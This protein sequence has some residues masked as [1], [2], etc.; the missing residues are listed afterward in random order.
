MAELVL[1][2]N[3]VSYKGFEQVQISR[4]M[5][6]IC[7]GFVVSAN[8]FF[9]GGTNS[10]QIKIGQGV[11]IE[12]DGQLVLDG[13]IDKMPI[14][15]G[16][17]TDN[18]EIYGRDKT[19]DLVDCCFDFTPNE[20]KNQ[21][22]GNL[23]KNL[24]NPFGIAVEVDNTATTESNI[25]VETFK[26]NEGIPVY[27]LISEL[28]RDQ[29]ILPLCYGDGKLTLTKAGGNYA[30]DSI[31][32]GI[33]ILK[34]K[35]LL[36]NEDRYSSYKVKG[37]GIGTDEKAL[38]DFISCFGEFSDGIITRTRPYVEFAESVTNNGQCKKK[39][40][41]IAR[42]KAGLSRANVYSISNWIQTTGKVWKINKLVR[43]KDRFA[44]ID[45]TM[46][47]FSVD[48]TYYE[49][50]GDITQIMVC[51]KNT[52][53]LSENEITIKSRFDA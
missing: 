36:D 14:E 33:N 35:L 20:W 39:A 6:N 19:S 42:L 22:V 43:V 46:L 4:S 7:G 8:N 21:T 17:N 15:Y 24:C 25:K 52:F 1:K 26:A 30:D 16:E 2:I 51:D 29:G 3:N 9:Q 34:G 13:W 18:I 27:E 32:D 40:I 23:I 44:G 31:V 38:A 5:L 47:I 10:Q 49:E 53:S 45:T 11:K 12:I 50:G 48:Y 28:C 37:Y 41:S